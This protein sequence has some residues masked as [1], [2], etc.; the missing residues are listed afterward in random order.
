MVNFAETNHV[1]PPTNVAAYWK[2][3]NTEA[4][5]NKLYPILANNI[6]NGER[7]L[8]SPTQCCSILEE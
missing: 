4:C 8:L 3:S 2:I 5:A 7:G 1:P 6:G